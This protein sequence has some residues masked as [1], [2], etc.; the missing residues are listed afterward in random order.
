MSY[1]NTKPLV[2]GLE[3]GLMKDAIE[4]VYDYPSRVAAMLMNDEIDV[5]L[6][7]VAIIPKLKQAHIITD[8][9]IGSEGEVAS[10][11]IFSELPLE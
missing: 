11:C 8:Y 2:Y 3:K 10:V 4:L 5:G 6:V 7:P 1:L 9:C